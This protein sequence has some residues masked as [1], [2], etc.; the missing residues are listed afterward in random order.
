MIFGKKGI[1]AGLL[2][3]ALCKKHVISKAPYDYV[4]E[5][6][7]D[8]GSEKN[9][10]KGLNSKELDNNEQGVL[11]HWEDMIESKDTDIKEQMKSV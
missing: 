10:N 6:F 7:G 5:K 1:E 3:R 2:M 8:I 11:K 4:K 9:Y